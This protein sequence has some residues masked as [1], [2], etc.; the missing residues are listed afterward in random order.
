MQAVWAS[1]CARDA[2]RQRTWLIILLHAVRVLL[3]VC[4][5]LLQTALQVDE[6]ALDGLW[7]SRAA[8]SLAGAG[9]RYLGPRHSLLM[10]TFTTRWTAPEARTVSSAHVT[11]VCGTM[12]RQPLEKRGPNLPVYFSTS[13]GGA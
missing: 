6:R 5:R 7:A 13:L 9:G 4:S 8:L 2:G 1:Q 11:T 3:V 12:L 10:Q